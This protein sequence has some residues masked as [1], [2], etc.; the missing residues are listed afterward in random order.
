MLP[1]LIVGALTAFFR[2]TDIGIAVRASAENADRATLLGISVKRLSTIVWIIAAGPVV[3]DE[4][5]GFR[6]TH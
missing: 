3:R 1:A 4:V 2:F 5:S 6:V